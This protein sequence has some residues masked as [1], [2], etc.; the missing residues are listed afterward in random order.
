META[1]AA[2]ILI[3]TLDERAKRGSAARLEDMEE[4]AKIM[5][6]RWSR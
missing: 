1:S 4:T 2:E 6:K 5:P 3:A